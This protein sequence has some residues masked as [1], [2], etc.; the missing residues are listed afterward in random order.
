MDYKEKYEKLVEQI[1]K[2][3]TWAKEMSARK[4]NRDMFDKGA[5]FAYDSIN[6]LITELEKTVIHKTETR[7][8]IYSGSSVF[9]AKF[10]CSIMRDRIA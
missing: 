9:C 7:C 1:K 8:D 2:E 10:T 6:S 5:I 4:D 3:T